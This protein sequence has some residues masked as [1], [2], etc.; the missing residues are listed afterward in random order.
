MAIAGLVA[1]PAAAAKSP[2]Q[3][4][5]SDVALFYRVYDAAHGAPTGDDLQSR[6]IEAGTDGVRQFVPNR[7]LSGEHLA[8]VIAHRRPAYERARNCQTALPK[9]SAR[10]SGAFRRLARLYP[11]AT[12]V[13][14]TILIGAD[15]S[16]GTTGPSGVLVG[17]EVVCTP[18]P[19]EKS[20]ADLLYHLIAH[21]YGHIQQPALLAG[22]N[23]PTT[24]LR[25]SLIEGAPELVS[26]LITGEPS[27]A[28]LAKWTRGRERS[29]DEAFLKDVGSAD[30]SHWLYNG[31]GTPE[32]PGDLG[33]WVGYR[34]AKAYY[35]KASDKHAALR[36]LFDLKDP[37]AILAQS[38]WA[39]GDPG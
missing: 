26:D 27:A 35:D 30:L 9:V 18:Q 36:T 3:I 29:L 21:E 19:F 25:Q 23:A 20:P 6:Y 15:N 11:Q 28:Y 39:P 38:G 8:D 32:H 1:S 14:V 22:E 10:L 13:P 24:V 5:A 16:G 12:F 33:Y 31:T 37:Q 2:M 7:I 4:R 17:L 34:I